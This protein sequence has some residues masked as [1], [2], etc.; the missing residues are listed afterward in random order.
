[1]SDSED[2]Q[3]VVPCS[4]CS[5]PFEVSGMEW[6]P[7]SQCRV[8]LKL[9]D[10]VPTPAKKQKLMEMG[11]AEKEAKLAEK[12]EV[13]VPDDEAVDGD[14]N[15]YMGLGDYLGGDRDGEVDEG[16]AAHVEH[17]E[18]P[19]EKGEFADTPM[20]EGESA[21]TPVETG[22]FPS[23]LVDKEQ[24]ADTELE[25]TSSADTDA[26][27]EEQQFQKAKGMKL[28]E[29]TLEAQLQV[30]RTRPFR[31]MK[32]W[33][34]VQGLMEM[35]EKDGVEK[36]AEEIDGSAGHSQVVG[37]ARDMAME[38]FE[39][40]VGWMK[41]EDEKRMQGM[42]SMK[43]SKSEGQLPASSASSSAAWQK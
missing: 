34:Q 10:A 43:K 20:E 8:C 29:F 14:Q 11:S 26:E 2:M 40:M 15:K 21:D 9:W 6:P 42:K 4:T 18:S 32:E 17:A 22:E 25:D 12:G 38:Y 31:N 19:V 16:E 36:M 24:C 1:M 7:V 33:L 41:E 30:W 23:T 35:V 27:A 37:E 13:E 39:A 28:D 3:M 5:H